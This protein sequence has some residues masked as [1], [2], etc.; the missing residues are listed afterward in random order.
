MIAPALPRWVATVLADAEGGVDALRASVP[1]GAGDPE[2]PPVS[3]FNAIDHAWVARTAPAEGV[4]PTHWVL[5]VNVGEEL[6]LGGNPLRSD[7]I[8]DTATV[9]VLLVGVTAQGDDAA[10]LASAHRLMRVVRRCLVLAFTACR[11]TGLT[12]EGQA[13]DLPDD[14]TLLTQEPEPGSGA[15]AIALVIPFTM[16]DMWALGA[17]EP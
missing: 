8:A 2:P 12:L 6:Q 14:L 3:V 5:Q 1:R 11:T 9:V 15:I 16:T 17:Q 7:P 10:T 4:T 13:F